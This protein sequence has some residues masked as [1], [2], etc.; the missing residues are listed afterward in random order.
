MNEIKECAET[1]KAPRKHK[2]GIEQTVKRERFAGSDHSGCFESIAPGMSGKAG[3]IVVDD[4]LGY[5]L[6]GR[7]G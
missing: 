4:L 2:T 1:V 5:V 3:E 7:L 6:P